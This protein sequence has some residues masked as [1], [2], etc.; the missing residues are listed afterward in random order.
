[1]STTDPKG[2]V[3]IEPVVGAG[4]IG[5]DLVGA[6]MCCN[7]GARVGVNAVAARAGVKI[8]SCFFGGRGRL[9]PLEVFFL[10]V[11]CFHAD[12]TDMGGRALE[13]NIGVRLLY[14]SKLQILNVACQGCLLPSLDLVIRDR[15]KDFGG[16]LGAP[17]SSFFVV[18]GGGGSGACG[19]APDEA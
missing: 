17:G 6:A 3:Q 4:G 12:W 15:D 19:W 5:E 1:M 14:C 13:R 16:A 8:T 7:R 2:L 10:F 18:C 9:E 11:R